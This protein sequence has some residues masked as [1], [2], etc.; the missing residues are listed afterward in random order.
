MQ[1]PLMSYLKSSW[2]FYIIL[3]FRSRAWDLL[4]NLIALMLLQALN[5]NETI[6][7]RHNLNNYHEIPNISPG[8]IDTFKHILGAYIRGDLYS[9]GIL[10]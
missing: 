10:C 9:E 6:P 2:C 1:V 4:Q 7:I 5:N 3:M 8:L